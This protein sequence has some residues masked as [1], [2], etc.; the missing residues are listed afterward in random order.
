MSSEDRALFVGELQPSGF[1]F[2]CWSQLDVLQEAQ[3]YAR[4]GDT[5]VRIYGEW[6]WIMYLR[7]DTLEPG[8]PSTR[9]VRFASAASN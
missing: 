6:E 1:T 2:A 7:F 5:A 9:T 3:A 4:A 8:K